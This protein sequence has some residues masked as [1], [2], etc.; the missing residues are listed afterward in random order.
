MQV[1]ALA[2]FR[3]DWATAAKTYQTAYAEVTKVVTPAPQRFFEVTAVAEQI[4]IKVGKQG[5]VY[6]FRLGVGGCGLRAVEG[7]RWTN[8]AWKEMLA[9]SLDIKNVSVDRNKLASRGLYGMLVPSWEVGSQTG[10][11][12]ERIVRDFLG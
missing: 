5:V 4:H 12:W 8:G 6:G 7:R 3:Q 11:C 9:L 10:G 2:E 1:A